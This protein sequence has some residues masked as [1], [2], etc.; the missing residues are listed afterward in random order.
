MGTDQSFDDVS[1]NSVQGYTLGPLL[2]G[3]SHNE[4]KNVIMAGRKVGT[5]APP[6]AEI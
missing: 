5:K 4:H 1:Y 3:N 6:V 2:C